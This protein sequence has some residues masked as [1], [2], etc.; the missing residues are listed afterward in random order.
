MQYTPYWWPLDAACARAPSAENMFT[1]GL[2][3]GFALSVIRFVLGIY[4]FLESSRAIQTKNLEDNEMWLTYWIVQSVF[5][6]FEMVGDVLISWIPFYYFAK[7]VFVVWLTIPLFQVG[8]A[9]V[10][11]CVNIIVRVLFF[12]FVIHYGRERTSSTRML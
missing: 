6:V 2:S 11:L 9:H 7:T 4:A 1:V 5:L 12:I 3:G 10:S 8:G